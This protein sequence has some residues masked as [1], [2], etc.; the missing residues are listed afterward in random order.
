[1][2]GVHYK[3]LLYFIMDYRPTLL[4]AQF[5]VFSGEDKTKEQIAMF[6]AKETKADKAVE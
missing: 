2:I 3:V 6:L 5:Q 1:M 4:S